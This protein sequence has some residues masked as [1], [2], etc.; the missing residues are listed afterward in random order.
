MAIVTARPPRLARALVSL[1]IRG[2]AREVIAGDLDEEFSELIAAG[3]PAPT[4]TRHYWRQSVASI[5]A[6]RRAGAEQKRLRTLEA[7][8]MP[9][10][11]SSM[12][13]G[14]GLDSRQVFRTLWRSKGYATIAVLSLAIGI[15]ANTAI[16][17]LVRHLLIDPLPIE[18]PQEVG[19]PYWTETPGTN[20]PA[21]QRN[22]S[23]YR[24]PANGQS[25]RS[26]Y[27]YP[28]YRALRAAVSKPATLAAFNFIRQLTVSVDGQ[29]PL[30]GS[31]MLVSGNF[32]ATLKPP[33]ELGRPISD[34]DDVIGAPPVVVI[35][36]QLWTRAFGGDRSAVGKAIR[37]NGTLETIVGVTAAPYRGLSQGGFFPQ[38]DVAI[39]ITQQPLIVPDWSPDKSLFT[40]DNLFW[41]RLLARTPGSTLT[42]A[43]DAMTAAQ[44]TALRVG[45]VAED[46]SA[47]AIVR[48]LPGARGL[49]SLRKDTERP[50]KILA[51]VVGLVLLMACVNVA[52]LL[53]ARGVARQHELALKR[54]LG[55]SRFRLIRELLLESVLLAIAGG[56]AGVIVALL[57]SSIVSSMLTSGLGVRD[58]GISLDWRLLSTTAALSCLA[59]LLCGCLPALRFSREDGGAFL[60]ARTAGAGGARLTT[61]R[62]LLAL[63]LAVSLPL[64]VG[65]GLFL[66]TLNNLSNVDLGFNPTGLVLFT[67]DPTLNGKQPERAAIVFPQVLEHL[68]ALPG[69]TSAT[70]IEN[71]LISGI[72]SNTMVTIDGQKYPMYLNTVGPRYFETFGVRLIA[73]R[74]FGSQDRA[75]AP[76]VVVV[77][78]TAA[79][80][81]FPGHSALGRYIRWGA[82][83]VEVVGVVSDSKYDGLRNDVEPTLFHP[84]EQTAG[85]VMHVVLRAGVPASTL[86]ASIVKAVADV[87]PSLP[88]ADFKTQNDQIDQ[89]VGKER[90]FA[91]LL[92]FFG[93]FALLL[94][95]LGLHGVT[96][97]SVTRRTS[98]IGIRLALGARRGQ[99][100][101]LIL[102]QVFVLAIA[103]LAVGLPIAWLAGP[104]IGS[105]LYGLSPGDPVTI[106]AASA[107]LL[108][109]ALAAGFLPARRAATLDALSALRID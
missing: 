97:Y 93:A 80:K 53:L 58:V 104:A 55:S 1:C 50:L 105:F 85:S 52:G 60:K 27:S 92:T 43:A 84:Y 12:F 9:D 66:R 62:A 11:T 103:G 33:M 86:R 72:M 73:G 30:P 68:E 6:Y 14:L 46:A 101:W 106:V 61:G 10:T 54:A 67:L 51:G 99:V 82:R 63:Q 77:N 34:G 13:Q 26:N 108:L 42:P 39:P 23:G 4:A 2:E 21:M 89:M 88:I 19:L 7:T 83:D 32:F 107:V 70:L 25:Y 75:G 91:G 37:I 29:T 87:D 16:F 40:A 79:R 95:C 15:G 8:H 76:P 17:G 81:Y 98:E 48:V 96:S 49:D 35:S 44:R 5:G 109:V 102:R 74:D 22:S 45:G 38:S 41:V 18:R 59:G 65:A 90:T 64:V 57:G 94:A 24:D 100:L 3:T 71:T 47:G 69:V 20:I 56:I 31:G 28:Q 78:D 36:H